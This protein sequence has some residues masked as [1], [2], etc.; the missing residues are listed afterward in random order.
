VR[1]HAQQH[2]FGPPRRLSPRTAGQLLQRP[3][4]RGVGFALQVKARR[5]HRRQVALQHA[6][7]LR[8]RI[9]RL[10][11]NAGFAV[12]AEDD[13]STRSVTSGVAPRYQWLRRASRWSRGSSIRKLAS[14]SMRRKSMYRRVCNWCGVLPQTS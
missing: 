8:Q 10:V 11:G 13:P 1:V 14:P 3:G 12:E 5:Q 2:G 4:A 9:T 7:Q 6:V